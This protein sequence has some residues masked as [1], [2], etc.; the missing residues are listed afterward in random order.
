MQFVQQYIKNTTAYKAFETNNS[1][2][3][4]VENL[5]GYPLYAMAQLCARKLPGHIWVICPTDET[6]KSFLKDS[7]AFNNEQK[8]FYLPSSGRVF[9]SPWEGTTR[10]Y[11]QLKTLVEM[12]N[13]K[14]AI[15]VTTIRSFVSPIPSKKYLNSSTLSI[16]V[17]SSFEQET[18]LSRLAE[19]RYFRSPSTS[20][21]GEFS[22]KGEV[23]DIFPHTYDYPVRIYLDW[24]RVEKIC[25][26][27]PISQK[28]IKTLGHID[29]PVVSE[30]SEDSIEL[31]S[32]SQ[33]LC[34]DDYCFF[35][36]DQ[37]LF[38]SLKSLQ[39]EAKGLYRKAYQKDREATKP[40]DL[41]FD[42][43]SF[44]KTNNKA[45][46]ISDIANTKIGNYKLDIDGP[47][48]YFGN[49]TLLKKELRGLTSE[50]WKIIISAPTQLQ[51]NRLQQMLAGISNLEFN[52]GDISSGFS[53]PSI[54]LMVIC[55]SE[56]F[57]R[58]KQLVKTL[59]HTEASPIDSFV[60]L[61]EGDYVVHVNYGI[62][63]FIQIDRKRE[64]DYIKIQYAD[65][66]NLYVPI[67]QTNLIQRYIGSS[68]NAPKLD[69]LGGK[70]WETKKNKAR[71]KAEE[72]AGRLISLYARRQKN[73]GFPF[74]KDNDWQLRFEAEFPYEETI[75]QLN[76]IQEIKEDM[77][78]NRVMDRLVCGDVGYG[79]TEI[80]FRA[81][82]KA[83]LSGKQVAFLAPTTIL[84]EQHY[85]NFI[86]RLG[87]FP[88]SVGLLSRM[89][90]RKTIKKTLLKLSE[91]KIDVLFGT[92]RILQKDVIYPNLGI[93]IVDEE[94][95]FGVKDK[96][97][98]KEVKTSIDCLSLSATPIPRTLYMSLLKIR[99][100]SILKTPPLERKPINT[101]IKP[102]GM[103]LIET[104]IR[105]EIAREGQVFYLHNRIETLDAV[106]NMLQKQMPEVS[107]A[108]A[109]GQMSG[110]QLEDIMDRFIHEGIQVLI[111]TTIIENGID[112][113]NVN[114]IIID[115]ADRY[116][117]AQLYQLKGRVGRS[118]KEAYAYLLYPAE[119]VLSEIA[120]KRLKIISRNT[121]L[122]SGFK[123][124]MKDL[125]LRGA[126]N[127]LGKDQSGNMSSVGLDMYLRL[128]DEAITKLSDSEATIEKEVLIDLDYSGFIPDSYVN[129]PSVKMELY[130]KIAGIKTKVELDNLI[131]YLEDSFGSVPEEVSNLLY[132][133]QLRILCRKLE[134]INL[135]ERRGAVTIEL[136]KV[137]KIS[138]DKLL[139]LIRTTSGDV[140]VDPNKPNILKMKTTAISLKDKALFILERL[141]LLDRNN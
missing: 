132:I 49:F 130:K 107:M 19:G 45:I 112:I 21:E 124:A 39:L 82:F 59:Q 119:Q 50:N 118:D 22:V 139:T 27:D 20:M 29:I 66:E 111:S 90:D 134:I 75:D 65:S 40:N 128:L 16:K 33:Y 53:I 79:K 97:R 105:N 52:L 80:A 25:E 93:L 7:E 123:V 108:V 10:E 64:R 96:E 106:L 86:E 9:Y 48:S 5:E 68:G 54:K 116:G 41:I 36:G 61:N 129:E 127:I 56:I 94:Q 109:H 35:V 122:G 125:E 38:T 141:E 1:R 15:I 14:K 114:T 77:E 92:H 71:K 138:I 30:E 117:V 46:V 23:V 11:Q 60:E 104:A 73:A 84:A 99:D 74:E 37:S 81:A 67:E 31:S 44:Y 98:I 140:T 91:G 131:A 55:D 17:G 28:S 34:K 70:G 135:K 89:V 120:I 13:Q 24:D 115:R 32:I 3:I 83:V 88:V 103:S 72:L 85:R 113:R 78:S 126:G 42:F 57:G 47:R 87:S 6:A 18:F 51:I 26:Y 101:I 8:V 76:C 133:A 137:A 58:R 110:Q 62:G 4:F 2:K 136:G 102:F 43:E 63:R 69:K 121:D 95:R 12:H 100:M